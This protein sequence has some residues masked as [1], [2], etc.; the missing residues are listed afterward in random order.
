MFRQ[1]TGLKHECNVEHTLQNEPMFPI[2]FHKISP[3]FC[4]GKSIPVSTCLSDMKKV[5]LVLG[6]A[7]GKT[8]SPHTEL[9]W[10][11]HSDEE[12]TASRRHRENAGSHSTAAKK[13]LRRHLSPS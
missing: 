7:L 10:K 8:D 12:Q 9:S 5:S 2:F 3:S 4:F 1:H 11:I 13:L 6:V